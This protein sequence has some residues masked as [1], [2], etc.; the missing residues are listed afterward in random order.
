MID[1]LAVY[2][3][4]AAGEADYT[5]GS[6]FVAGG[7]S[8]GLPLF[9]RLSIPVVSL[10]LSLG[11]G[12]RFTDITCGFRAYTLDILDRSG[13]NLDQDWLNRYELEY[14]IHYQ[15]SQLRDARIQEVPVTIDYAHLDKGRTSKIKPFVG[16]WSMIRPVLLLRLGLR[17]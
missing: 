6:R 13:A 9:R 1:Q 17:T 2:A 12:R 4:V 8:P 15:V 10:A 11:I 7:G 16:W 3:P 14:Y 5:T